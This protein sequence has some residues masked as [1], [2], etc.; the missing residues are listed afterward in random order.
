MKMRSN[1][2]NGARMRSRL[3]RY[4][5]VAAFCLL[6]AL[7][8]ANTIAAQ[9]K[10]GSEG[11]KVVT[12]EL[13]EG[14]IQKQIAELLVD[15]SSF[16][17][18][19]EANV[20]AIDRD[21]EADVVQLSEEE[22]L[23]LL[24]QLNDAVRT[25]REEVDAYTAILNSTPF[26]VRKSGDH[27]Y[28][29]IDGGGNIKTYQ[30][31]PGRDQNN[32]EVNR[33]DLITGKQISQVQI[34]DGIVQEVYRYYLDGNRYLFG[35]FMYSGQTRTG[36]ELYNRDRTLRERITF[37]SNP[38]VMSV[39]VGEDKWIQWPKSE[40]EFTARINLLY[41]LAGKK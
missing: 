9:Q 22:R 33:Y 6:S 1:P 4:L 26:V 23:H 28:V 12:G 34:R 32:Y 29:G 5:A 17:R 40:E 3:S 36:F 7:P 2:V 13:A 24:Q 16:L 41:E 21:I 37:I 8:V 35:K 18:E 30:R 38:A 14:M 15:K 11:P 10:A 25:E 19:L 20:K 27:Y 31:I 39:R